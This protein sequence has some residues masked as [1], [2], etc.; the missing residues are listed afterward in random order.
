[1]SVIVSGGRPGIV[2]TGTTNVGDGLTRRTVVRAG[3]SS[4]RYD[5]GFKREIFFLNP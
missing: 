4:G 2:E 3:R 1:M 5:D